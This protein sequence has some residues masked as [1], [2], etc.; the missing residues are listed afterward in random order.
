M[1]V[2]GK[3]KL[4]AAALLAALVLGVAS[5]AFYMHHSSAALKQEVF[6]KTLDYLNQDEA[7]KVHVGSPVEAGWHVTGEIVDKGETGQTKLRF[8]ITGDK[9]KGRVD[10]YS[11]KEKGE[12]ILF[13]VIVNIQGSK[14]R[15]HVY[16]PQWIPRHNERLLK[17]KSKSDS[18][19]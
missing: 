2:R 14:E 9:G 5:V 11:Y 10:I 1:D 19:T 8:W 17:N 13:E 16:S 18:E 12:W 4:I 15:I 7:V 3:L 6:F